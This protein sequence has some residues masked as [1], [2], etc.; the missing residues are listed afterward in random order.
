MIV[1]QVQSEIFVHIFR[2]LLTVDHRITEV[3]IHLLGKDINELALSLLLFALV[4]EKHLSRLIFGDLS[5]S[6]LSL[7]LRLVITQH[8]L[9][10][11]QVS[12]VLERYTR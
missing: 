6:R 7:H 9:K 8:L 3:C 11:A 12:L 5:L 2:D 10:Y 4:D 1:H